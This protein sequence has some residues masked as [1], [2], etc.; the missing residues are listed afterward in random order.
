MNSGDDLR[1]GRVLERQQIGAE[2]ALRIALGLGYRLHRARVMFG[3][4]GVEHVD[5]RNIQA[6]QPDDR[7][8][9]RVAVVVVGPR[10][11][12]NEVA[13]VHR[14]PLAIDGGVGALT[15]DD[16]PKR[17]GGV[18]VGA[19]DFAGQDELQPGV[20]TLRD[21][22][23][24]V[25]AGIFEDEDAPLGFLGGDEPSGFHQQR[26]QF[27]VAPERRR[28]TAFAARAERWRPARS[29]A[30]RRSSDRAGR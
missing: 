21:S 20:Q 3:E 14:R 24:A 11:R 7:L 29:R 4:A 19:G 25:Q 2:T 5:D 8:V 17:G 13:R 1:V 15:L 10:R 6:V 26:P 22:R 23:R 18:A 28:R 30:A 27:V 12:Q 9:A 16:Q